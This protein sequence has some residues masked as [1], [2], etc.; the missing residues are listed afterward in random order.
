MNLL[1]KRKIARRLEDININ[2]YKSQDMFSYEKEL[3]DLVDEFGYDAD[4][5]IFIASTIKPKYAK[6]MPKLVL[7]IEE[8]MLKLGNRGLI[9]FAN[10]IKWAN[11]DLLTKAVA[12]ANNINDIVEFALSVHHA[13][14]EYLVEKLIDLHAIDELNTLKRYLPFK[15]RKQ[16]KRMISFKDNVL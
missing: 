8:D 9:L 12:D 7:K 11:I 4:C 13:K 5:L 10:N 1:D 14:I 16:I 2:F 15:D 3:I 6:Q